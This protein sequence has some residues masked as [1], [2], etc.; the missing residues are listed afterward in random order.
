MRLFLDTSALLV[1]L[2]DDDGDH[3]RVADALEQAIG[4]GDRLITHNYVVSEACALAQRRL[5]S[6]AA[7]DL[8][9][10]VVPRLEMAFVTLAIHASA[11]SAFVANP[12]RG[13]SLVD[14]VSFEVMRREGIEVALAL[15][16]DFITAGFRTL[17]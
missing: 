8:L 1:L 5:G 10:V 11:V 14:R 4:R 12:S 9:R 7:I 3:Q 2:D 13:V 15:D 16:A 6:N 17:P